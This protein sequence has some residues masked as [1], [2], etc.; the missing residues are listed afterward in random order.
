[1]AETISMVVSVSVCGRGLFLPCGSTGFLTDVDGRLEIFSTIEDARKCLCG[2]PKT[3]PEYGTVDIDLG[4]KWL[5]ETS[6]STS[7]E[8]LEKLGDIDAVH[9]NILLAYSYAKDVPFDIEKENL[10][11]RDATFSGK[12]KVFEKLSNINAREMIFRMSPKYNW[13]AEKIV[14]SWGGRVP[15]EWTQEELYHLGMELAVE[16]DFIERTLSAFEA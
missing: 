11:H 12:R 8:V 5:S 10:R 6:K 15:N 14:Q 16:I 4:R 7:L 1:M 2:N 3:L 9:L 13:D